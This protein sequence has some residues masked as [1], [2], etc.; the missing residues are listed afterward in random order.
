MDSV[1]TVTILARTRVNGWYQGERLGGIGSY[2]ADSIVQEAIQ[3]TPIP[4]FP[5]RLCPD[6]SC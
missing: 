2:E 1:Q 4:S 5:Y 6:P 3:P